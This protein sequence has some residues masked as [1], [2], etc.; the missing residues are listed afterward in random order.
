MRLRRVCDGRLVG[1]RIHINRVKHGILRSDGPDDPTPPP[2]SDALEPAILADSELPP[3]SYVEPDS[4][5][6]EDPVA[7]T[8]VTVAP[9]PAVAEPQ[10]P[11]ASQIYEI[12]KV[13]CKKFTQD[14]WQYCVKWVGF[15]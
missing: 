3:N 15:D 7:Q 5:R 10:Q 12:E 1:N 6:P 11:Q 8:L 2:D 14:Q 9:Q 4:A 13:L